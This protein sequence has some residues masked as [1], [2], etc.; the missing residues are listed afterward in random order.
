MKLRCKPGDLAIIVSADHIENIGKLV[1]IV[2][3]WN[4]RME[5]NGFN[6]PLSATAEW[7]VEC[8]GTA[9]VSSTLLSFVRHHHMSGPM[10][11]NRLRPIRGDEQ[12]EEIERHQEMTA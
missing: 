8:A 2:E 7:L 9:I 5:Y 1:R 11:D 4:G 12:P 10:R 6:W 3:P